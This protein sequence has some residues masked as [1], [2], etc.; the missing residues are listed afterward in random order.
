MT[1]PARCPHLG[2]VATL[3]SRDGAQDWR[4]IV[5]GTTG[6]AETWREFDRQ[7]GCADWERGRC[8]HERCVELRQARRTG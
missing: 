2:R 8:R 7:S 5:C 1:D 3:L 4:C 6:H